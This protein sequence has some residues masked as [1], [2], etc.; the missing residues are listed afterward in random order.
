[1]IQK[2][3]FGTLVKSLALFAFAV[4]LLGKSSPAEAG[5]C[6]FT[7]ICPGEDSGS[8]PQEED[9]YKPTTLRLCNRSSSKVFVAYTRNMGNK[10]W[11]S[12]GWY[13]VEA[14]KCKDQNI[15]TYNGDVYVYA[16]AGSASWGR[17]DASFCVHNTQGFSYPNSDKMACNSTGQKRVNMSRW[18]VSK[19]INT[20]N[21]N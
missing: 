20:H 8:D 21:F 18:S 13:Q 1:M 6:S 5:F 10:G 16:E 19:G 17:S 2:N 12:S 4:A 7:G 3:F 14:G 15:G 9:G 11:N